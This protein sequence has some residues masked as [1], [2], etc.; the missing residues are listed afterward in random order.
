MSTTRTLMVAVAVA[1]A[2]ALAVTGPATATNSTKEAVV[3]TQLGIVTVQGTLITGGSVDYQFAINT[4]TNGPLRVT[5]LV[6]SAV[7]GKKW[8]AKLPV[9]TSTLPAGTTS[10]TGPFVAVPTNFAGNAVLTVAVS[11]KGRPVAT[12]SVLFTIN[13]AP[14]VAGSVATNLFGVGFE[15]AVVLNGALVPTTGMGASL[16]YAW[17]QL[18]GPAG[19]KAP[20]VLS[21]TNALAPTLTTASVTNFVLLGT[22]INVDDPDDSGYN[23]LPYVTPE[24]R[25]GRAH[26]LSLDA[27]Q[28]SESTYVYQVLVSGSSITRTGTFTVTCA[29][30]TPAHPNIPL[31][32]VTSFL[33]NTNST[34]WSLLAPL[35]STATL[36]H[37]NSLTP[38]LV[39]DVEGVYIIKDNVTGAISTNTVATWTGYQFCAICHGHN[40]NVG[41]VD[42]ITPWSKTA[43]ASMFKNGINGLNGAFYS[44]ACIQC[45]TVG[46][47]KT[48]TAVNGGFDDI[49]AL[50]GWKFPATLNSNNWNSVPA[51]LQAVANIQCENCH[52]PGSQH[53]GAP[54]VTL[55]ARVCEHCHQD[56]HF[57]T[58]PQQWEVS[59]HAGAYESI[60]ASEGPNNQCSRCHSPIGFLGAA[61][62]TNLVGQ[63]VNI[64]NTNTIP[65][66]MGPLTCQTCHDPHDTHGDNPDRFQL[67]VFDQFLMGNPY[68]RS[69]NVY[70]ALGASL[71]TADLRLTNSNVIVTNAGASAAC[72]TCHNGRQLPTQIQLIGATAGQ[73]FLNTTSS[74]GGPHDSTVAEA[75]TGI[76]AY[77]YGQP[78][79]NSFHTYLADCQ[80][81]HMYQ[82]R[83]PAGTNI[84]DQILVNGVVTDVDAATYAQY[85]DLLGNHTFQMRYITVA[86]GVTNEVDNIAACNQCHVNETG[87]NDKVSSFDFK[88]VDGQDYDG[89]GVA[90]GIQ[91]ET[92]GLLNNLGFLLRKT[93][94]AITTNTAGQ[95]ISV[96]TGGYSANPAIQAAQR[97]AVWNWLVCY[98]EGSFGVHNS[99]FTVRLLQTSF[100]D[101]ST[102]AFGNSATNTF[103]GKFPKAFLR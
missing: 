50:T 25:F 69:N 62:G 4:A 28:V 78:T 59:P 20:G 10:I 56:G 94:I 64:A 22:T 41:Q 83:A 79:G 89:D 58:R 102:N 90:A 72:L 49:Q 54:S 1:M 63:V 93:G 45:H 77:D 66:G 11:F 34:S 12:R 88:P 100:T 73:S 48:P 31:G 36:L 24:H 3:T 87:F 40:N 98:R 27:Q 84:L 46:Y 70:V 68:F 96:T 52:G 5:G 60:S 21:A 86:N 6:A 74:R 9:F 29:V 7:K 67:R 71:T 44:E 61:K 76:G 97:K 39:P 101:L 37:T 57:H 32:A 13:A 38:Q 26:A 19:S 30:Q 81:C 65:T 95:V 35:G 53:P 15:N 43:H 75:F 8:S 14:P 23:G 33:G 92:H 55:D 47:D 16:T 82:L 17:T 91:T 2:G 42:L 18:T 99:Q 85:K 80:A 51:Q 103:Q